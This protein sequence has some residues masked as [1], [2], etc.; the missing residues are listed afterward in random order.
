[1]TR[2]LVSRTRCR[3][4]GAR[5]RRRAHGH[6]GQPG[7]WPSRRPCTR[8][9][10][11]PSSAPGTGA[12]AGL[13]RAPQP[14]GVRSPPPRWGLASGPPSAA[15]GAEA[16]DRKEPAAVGTGAASHRACPAAVRRPPA[17]RTRPP[18]G[19]PAVARGHR[20]G[21]TVRMPPVT[22]TRPR[23]RPS[24]GGCGSAGRGSGPR[25]G[26]R[27]SLDHMPCGVT[28]RRPPAAGAADFGLGH[29]VLHRIGTWPHMDVQVPSNH[30]HS[31]TTAQRHP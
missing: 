30:S 27:L 14:P 19:P 17:A 7:A 24:P 25:R 31:N 12:S 23:G 26:G 18:Q 8:A 11:P 28:A 1:M 13:A 10:P 6:R 2:R 5:P 9:P 22:G 4:P 29:G 16:A 3:R 15:V 20:R 21:A